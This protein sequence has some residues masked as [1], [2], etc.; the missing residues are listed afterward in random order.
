MSHLGRLPRRAGLGLVALAVG[1]AAGCAPD[2]YDD[3]W[4]QNPNCPAQDT[5]SAGGTDTSGSTAVET[6]TAGTVS[7]EGGV[8]TADGES[9]TS[10]GPPV[11]C[12]SLDEQLS[13]DAH[14]FQ[15]LVDQSD[16]MQSMFDGGSRWSAVEDALVDAGSGEITQRQSVTRFGLTSYHGLQAG[17]PQLASVAPQ[18][19][20]ADEITAVLGMEM[21]AGHNPVADAVEAVADDLAADAWDGAKTLVLVLGDEP[22]TC[23]LPSPLNGV[24]FAITREAAES[25]VTAAFSAGFPTVVVAVGD[26]IEPAFLQ[27]L[28]NAGIGHQAGDPD[29]TFFVAQ[30]D[31]ALAAAFAEIFTPTRPCSFALELALPLELAPGCT[32]EVNGAPV[33]YDD[34]N[35]WSRPDEQTLAL[36]GTACEAIQEGDATVEMVCNCD[37]V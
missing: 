23:D 31:Q 26:D 27:L 37:D 29:A 11:L 34:P 24:D 4:L 19:D 5:D 3:G 13:F 30:D 15:L 12:P 33:T 25:A 18:L 6:E 8:M 36:Q 2:C 1:G 20:A 17:C 22:S 21:P 28:A 14:T 9:G 7:A 32:V 16:A 35:G 10:E